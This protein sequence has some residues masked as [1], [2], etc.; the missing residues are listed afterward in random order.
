M[1]RL[2]DILTSRWFVTLIAA[3]ILSALIWFCGPWIGLG[4]P[5]WYPLAGVVTRLVCIIVI[6]LIWGIGNIIGQARANRANKEMVQEL[7]VDPD[8]D[9]VDSERGD[10]AR[11]FEQ[12][13]ERLGKTKFDTATGGRL[14]YQLPWYIMIGPPGSG[15]TTA[16][17]NSGL[18]F[19]A[20]E[21]G[22][23][24]EIRGVG[25]TRNCDW[26]F[27]SDAVLID[28]AGRYTTQDSHAPVD[29]G[30]WEAFLDLLKKHRPRQPINGVMIAIS[31]GD[32]LVDENM[33]RQHAD[34]IRARLGE[35]S[36]RLGID[37]PVYLVVTK[38]DLIAGF[39]EFFDDLDNEQR[40]QVWGATFDPDMRT[41]APAPQVRAEFDRLIE[42]LDRRRLDRL[43]AEYDQQRRALIFDFPSQVSLLADP[44]E[45]FVAEAF[46]PEEW[47]QSPRL[48]GF[49]MTSGTQEGTPVD[50]LVAALSDNFGIQRPAPLGFAVAPRP[51]FLSRLLQQVIFGE[52]GLVARDSR[53][54]R[55]ERW[56]S[57]AAFAA[58]GVG[59]LLISGLWWWSYSAN[60]ERSVEAR[61]HLRAYDDAAKGIDTP[62]VL[63]NDIDVSRALPALDA[64]RQMPAGADQ[65][66]EPDPWSFGFGLSQRSR[67]ESYADAAYERGLYR[68][69][70]PRLLQRLEGDLRGRINDPDYVYEALK[71][72]LLL[73][74]RQTL[75]REDE[76][77]TSADKGFVQT[78]FDLDF[79]QSYTSADLDRLNQHVAALLEIPP[80]IE[81]HQI[82]LDGQL[83]GAA[84]ATLTKLPPSRRAYQ[85]LSESEA[86]ATL[87]GWKAS[88]HLGNNPSLFQRRSGAPLDPAVDGRFTY[89]AFHD[90]VLD[91]I[92][93]VAAD[94]DAEYWVLGKQIQMSDQQFDQLVREIRNLYYN[95]YI[96]SWDRFLADVT[97]R[98]LGDLDDTMGAILDL[99]QP[100]TSPLQLLMQSV[101]REVSLTV[102][103]PEP[104]EEGEEGGGGAGNKKL[105]K[106]GLKAAKKIGGPA[107]GK[108]ARLAKLAKRKGGSG[109]AGGGQAAIALPGQPVETHF[110]Y[111]KDLVQGGEGG[112]TPGLTNAMTT[113]GSV[114]GNL[115][116]M[117]TAAQTG[118]PVSGGAGATELKA[119]ASRLPPPLNEWLGG[120]AQTAATGAADTTRIQLNAFWQS[121]VLPICQQ[122][123][124]G[125]FPFSRASGQ[126]VNIDDFIRLFSPGG[127]I[128]AFFNTHLRARVDTTRRPWRWR[129]VD[130]Q[131]LGISNGVLSQFERAARIREGLFAAG[132]TPRAS[133]ELRPSSLDARASQVRLEIDGQSVEY[134]HG[135]PVPMRLTWPGPAGQN[136]A[137]LTFSPLGGTPITL[138]REGAWSWFRLLSEA[139]FERTGA[140]D[141]F[142]VTFAHAG[143]T[144]GFDLTAGSIA[145]PFDLSLFEGFRCPAGL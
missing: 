39:T 35:L 99:K 71:V 34:A 119:A 30:A 40:Q 6:V 41:D 68:L 19:P 45:R 76:E 60:A 105:A 111:L 85:L 83:I 3:A 90:V 24:A 112:G 49:Y 139:R 74:Q 17:T 92:D 31:A 52:A 95:D 129:E 107:V 5:P 62:E 56:I 143:F 91:E 28:T 11:S 63:S 18:K 141:R 57:Q 32:L 138:T 109:G 1:R 128:D 13:M 50:Q 10:L 82:A 66:G 110:A 145:N 131:S 67:M 123:L 59:V 65:A 84:R 118:Q 12:A 121:D 37:V 61:R 113:L 22:R 47:K 102:P 122:A 73:G 38:C 58:A 134:S 93:A 86:V 144:A 96:R 54:E 25:G 106:L 104:E 80:E 125:R 48:R 55:R 126:D 21:R 36:D 98:P 108:A 69:L 101:V 53:Y 116:A 133:F 7:Q 8:Q 70:L 78:W 142:S 15:K 16:L 79:E 115:Q 77:T 117:M 87:P 2:L 75:Y 44:L 29:Q 64:L 120:I 81:S 14:L 72:Y 20:R 26:F 46:A 124:S 100:G 97:L 23:Q 4:N 27:T 88:A 130:G 140:A 42:R 33:R 137:S 51:F 43:H 9:A 114:Y 136:L 103:P 127:A 132:T 94:V 89:D 135:P